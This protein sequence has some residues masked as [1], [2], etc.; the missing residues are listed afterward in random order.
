MSEDTNLVVASAGKSKFSMSM[1]SKVKGLSENSPLKKLKSQGTPRLTVVGNKFVIRMGGKEQVLKNGKKPLKELDVV[2]HGFSTQIQRQLSEPWNNE[3]PKFR[4]EGC[5][6][7]DGN[8]PDEK[9]WNKKSQDCDTCSEKLRCSLSRNLV[10]SLYSP[11]TMPDNPMVFTTNWS[12]NSTKKNGEDIDEMLF[13]LIN[14]LSFLSDNET[15]SFKVITRLV[16]D[17]FSDNKPANNCKVLFQ[18]VD[19]LNSK[20]PNWVAHEKWVESGVWDDGDEDYAGFGKMIR[21]EQRPPE[22]EV[23]G[24]SAGAGEDDS[25]EEVD[26]AAEEAAKKKAAAAAK[27]KKAAAAKK[28]REEEEAKKKEAED[29]EEEEVD[30]D[31]LDDDSEEEEIEEESEDDWGDLDGLLDED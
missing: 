10:V 6:S 27:R 2:I 16:I 15:E 12:S 24:D 29:E 22:D 13:S 19:A 17:D 8:T 7:N 9:A 18:P 4:P 25:E 21:I 1:F 31:D 26:T 11:E 28:K 20:S 3:D 14:Y 30:L 5:W 23:V